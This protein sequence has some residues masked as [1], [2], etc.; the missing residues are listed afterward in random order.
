MATDAKKGKMFGKLARLVALESKKAKGNINA[1]GLRTVIEKAKS[2]NM[3]NENIERAVKKGAGGDAGEMEEVLYEGY[4]P[5]GVAI[6][7]EGLTDNKNRT[8]AE[9]KHL[10]SKHGASLAA[11]GAAS[12]AFLPA[13]RTAPARATAGGRQAGEKTPE[14]FIPK[15]FVELSKE[16]RESLEKLLDELED[17]DDVQEIYTNAK[18]VYKVKSS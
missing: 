6:I 3:P 10:L 16:D 2:I 15:T 18:W 7:I 1:P 13:P 5:G 11:Q 9:I 17:N 8:S 12:W 4:G 14:G